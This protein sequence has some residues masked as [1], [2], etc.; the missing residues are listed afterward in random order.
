MIQLFRLTD[1]LC[2]ILYELS[3]KISEIQK[4]GSYDLSY[5]DPDKKDPLTSADLYANEY[6]KKNLKKLIPESWILS[7]ETTD[8]LNR[9]KQEYIWII[10]PID[11]TRDFINKKTSY[12]ISVGLVHK[13]KP[14]L[15]VVSMPAENY[16]VLG[17]NYQSKDQE[18]FILI[19]NFNTNQKEIIFKFEYKKKSLDIAKIL[20]SESEYKKN[21]FH[22]FPKHWHVEPTGS[23]ARKLAMVAINK[24]DLLISLV[25]KNEWDIC[26]GIALIYASQQIAYTL[27]TD[28]KGSFLI[29]SFNKKILTSIGLVAGNLYLV[30]DYLEFHKQHQIQTSNVY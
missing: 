26:G 29:P 2:T 23:V 17:V 7:E 3:Y 19:Y 18:P 14:V 9:L 13:N 21:R 30:Q 28:E 25:P 22:Q 6:L 27:E 10:D 16:L 11:G 8:N 12:A 20:V 15:G 1:D 4:Q 24:G 5:K